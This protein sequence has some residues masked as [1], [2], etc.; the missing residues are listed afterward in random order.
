MKTLVV[1]L[2]R[3]KGG[4]QCTAKRCHRRK[5]QRHAVAKSSHR[6]FFSYFRLLKINQTQHMQS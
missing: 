6:E 3:A 1:L 2:L 4:G 5:T